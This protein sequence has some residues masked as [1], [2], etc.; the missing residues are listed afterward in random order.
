MDH[1]ASGP[2]KGPGDQRTSGPKDQGT[3][4]GDQWTRAGLLLF[5]RS[6]LGGPV[7]IFID[8]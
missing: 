6:F 3:K 1:D 4:G 2:R 8:L 7:L 5:D